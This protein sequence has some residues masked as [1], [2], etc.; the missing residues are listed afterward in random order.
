MFEV[1]CADTP[2]KFFMIIL[3]IDVENLVRA[4][5]D[6]LTQQVSPT[7]ERDRHTY[8]NILKYKVKPANSLRRS[9]SVPAVG[10]VGIDFSP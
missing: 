7:S 3:A 4:A 1:E 8:R 5:P 2:L 10:A 9:G 6:F